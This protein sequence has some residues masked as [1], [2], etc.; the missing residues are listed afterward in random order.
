MAL[1]FL[2]RG[3]LEES[4]PGVFVAFEESP[5]E[6]A[7]NV[8]SLGWD[9]EDLQAGGLLAID[10]IQIAAGEIVEAGE[11]DLDG[12]LIRLGLAIDSVGA[13]RVVLDTV[14]ALFGALRN[15]ALLRSELR[16]LFRWLND[17][18]V[19]AIVTGERGERS[20]TRHGLEEYVSDCVIVLD[21]RVDD[22]TSTRRLR[23]VKYRGSHHGPDEYPFLIDRTGFSVLPVSAMGLEHAASSERVPSGVAEL[24][25]MLEG[26][27]YYRGS[28]VLVSGTPGAGK[29]TLGAR[30]LEAGCERGE[31]GLLFAFEESSAQIMRNMCSIGIDLQ[32]WVA[33]GGLRILAARPAAYGLETHLARIDQAVEEF[34]P[35]IVVLDPLSALD[36]EGFQLKSMLSRLIDA[37]KTRQITALMTTLTR[38]SF[39]ERAGLGISSVIDTWLDLSNFE[40][41]GERNRGIDVLKSRGMGHSNQV[42]EFLLSGSGIEI[43]DVY[44]GARG[45][46]VG[47]ARRAQELRDRAEADAYGLE[48][49]AKRRRL[50]SRRSALEAQIAALRDQLEAET[51]ELSGEIDAGERREREIEQD[52]AAIA[53]AR[54]GAG[55]SRDGHLEPPR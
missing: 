29:S 51:L 40:L 11:W 34:E 36:G 9:L 23:V 20:L 8:A 53:A 32:P 46:L 44:T 5:V 33:A 48:L 39:D 55:V 13:K 28:S 43:R 37:F 42:R 50:Q 30:F 12:L 26:G 38:G 2:V 15:E 31:R 47:S 1:Q 49:D 7:A 54:K 4:E 52:R 21:H 24:D 45:V 17:R 18:G 41:D 10:Q 25:A 22:Q 3:A 16:R 6:L 27:G 14:E 19:T 35:A